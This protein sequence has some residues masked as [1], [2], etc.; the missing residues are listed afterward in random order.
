MAV[1]KNPIRPVLLWCCVLTILV[2]SPATASYDGW[3]SMTSTLQVRYLDYFDDSIQ[4]V[5]SGG[6]LKIDPISGGLRKITSTDGTG[7]N[8]LYYIF[9]DAGGADWIAGY[10]RLVK[11]DQGHYTPYLFFDRDNELMTLYT[12]A[13]DGENLWVGTSAGLALFSKVVDGGQIEDFYFRFG[14]LEPE[15]VIYD[16]AI[17]GDSIWIATSGGLAVADKSDPKLLKS[18]V[19]WTAFSSSGYPELVVDEVTAVTYFRDTVYVG[20][21]SN[22]FQLTLDGDTSF[23]KLDT[24]EPIDVR[25]MIVNGD[26]LFI[27]ADGGFFIHSATG[28]AQYNTAAIPS[29]DFSA[30]RL[31]DDVHW[32]GLSGA[33]IYSG[34]ESAFERFDDGGLPGKYVTSLST[35]DDGQVSGAFNFEGAATFDRNDWETIDVDTRDWVTTV[36]YDPGGN[37]WMAIWGTGLYMINGETTINFDENNSSLEGVSENPAYVVVRDLAISGNYLFAGNYRARGGNS[38]SVFNLSTRESVSFGLENGI[39]SDRTLTIDAR[40]AM[41]VL[42]TS[43]SGIFHYY[44]GPDPFNKSD[45]SVVNFREDNSRL[46][47]NSINVVKYDND[48]IFWVGTQF[49]LLRYDYGVDNFDNIELPL[50]F[51][52]EVTSLTFDRR[53]NVWIG[54]R[55]GLA[56]RNAAT[57][58]YDIYTTLNSGLADNHITAL[59]ADPRTGDLWAGT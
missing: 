9:K 20:T 46:S 54:A 3:A 21:T 6:C 52:P 5:T 19:N 23:V 2:P 27:Y 48:G 38:V 1:E 53:N 45:D 18:F 42:G 40:G 30:G 50:G 37:L 11:F 26:S 56:R 57:G 29:S 4:V 47:S 17:S 43:N 41:F 39:T 33:G 12:I 35:A 49:G 10:G 7:T 13:D 51:G 8:D 15:P 34:V 28:T 24:F 55:N 32:L 22:A 36:T 58:E 25:H 31:V 59:M 16:I 14:D 44:V